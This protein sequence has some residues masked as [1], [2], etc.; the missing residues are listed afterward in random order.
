MIIDAHHHLWKLARGDYGWIGG[1]VNP[2]VV[3]IERDYLLEHYN[4]AARSNSVAGSVVVQAAPTIDETRWLLAQARAS[5]GLVRGV[6]GWIDMVDPDAPRVLAELAQDRLLKGIR[7]MLQD[8]A[9]VNWVLQRELDPAFRALIEHRLTFDVLIRPPHLEAALTLLQ[10]YPELRAV[11]D[12]CA[13]PDIAGGM[14]QPWADLMRRIA[15]E[16]GAYCK[17]S[18]LVTEA[19]ANW[20]VEDLRRYVEHILDCFGPERVVWGSDWPVMLLNADYERWLDATEAL[21]QSLSAPE[22]SRILWSNAIECY[23]LPNR[24]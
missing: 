11:I 17:L 10:R 5:D 16:T 2:A 1:G 23:R 18:G 22:R 3:A 12:H 20:R 7:P 9:D 14:W 19:K 6:V 24:A 13:K 8:I 4:M 15:R 21:L